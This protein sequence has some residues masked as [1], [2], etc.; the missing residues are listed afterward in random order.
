MKKQIHEILDEFEA[1]LTRNEKLRVLQNNNSDVLR[2]VLYYTFQPDIEWAIKEPVERRSDT[3]MDDFGYTSMEYAL[4]KLY[5]FHASKVLPE[6]KR[7]ILLIQTLEG[8][9]NKEAEVYQNMILKDLKIEGLTSA[10]VEEAFPGLLNF[11]ANT[12]KST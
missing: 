11:H 1:A 7:K 5:L 6:E 8:M 3:H 10:I 2:E 9:D 12:Q 4:R